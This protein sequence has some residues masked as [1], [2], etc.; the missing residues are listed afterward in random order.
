MFAARVWWRFVGIAAT[1]PRFPLRFLP[2]DRGELDF[3]R[4]ER[5]PP[6]DGRPARGQSGGL[7]GHARGTVR[8]HEFG[9]KELIVHQENDTDDTKHHL[10]AP[11][12]YVRS[13]VESLQHARMGLPGFGP[14]AIDVTCDSL[15][16]V[17]HGLD[18]ALA[19][20]DLH[21]QDGESL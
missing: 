3:C 10:V 11:H 21:G 8:L 17:M 13:G 16:A 4:G 14:S 5:P 19:A 6:A 12:S 9:A 2:R 20:L 15:E 1:T 18:C 7:S